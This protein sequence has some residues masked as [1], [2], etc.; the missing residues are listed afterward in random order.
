MKELDGLVGLVKDL[1]PLDNKVDIPGGSISWILDPK[2]NFDHVETDPLS[3]FSD[4]GE[5]RL[6]VHLNEKL[7]PDLTVD[8]MVD[9]KLQ[10]YVKGDFD[11]EFNL[12]KEFI[13]QNVQINFNIQGNPVSIIS[14]KG[15]PNFKVS[16]G[17][18]AQW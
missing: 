2:L 10:G 12:K 18:I 9:G 6:R 4:I 11:F 13:D 3:I 1:N 15:D 16:V 7:A 17:L 14:P 5:S 8:F